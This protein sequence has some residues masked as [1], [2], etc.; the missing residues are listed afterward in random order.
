[1]LHNAAFRNEQLG[2]VDP[3]LVQGPSPSLIGFAGSVVT[4]PAWES[5]SL[6]IASCDIGHDACTR[7]FMVLIVPN[8][9]N[10][11][12]TRWTS[13]TSIGSIWSANGG[14]TCANACAS[15][16]NLEPHRT[17]G[18]TQPLHN[19]PLPILSLHLIGDAM[20]GY[21]SRKHR[22]TAS[23]ANNIWRN[24]IT[25]SAAR[26]APVRGPIVTPDEPNFGNTRSPRHEIPTFVPT[27]YELNTLWTSATSPHQPLI[28]T[29]TVLVQR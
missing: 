6:F 9:S 20:Q 18:C 1:M 27:F 29:S 23:V 10:R 14:V 11:P 12:K 26:L 5:S 13:L 7:L 19:V 2:D 25:K 21:P 17:S 16:Q 8:P 24:L 4:S 22:I 3:R 28:T 15:L